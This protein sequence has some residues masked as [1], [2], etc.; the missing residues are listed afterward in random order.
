MKDEKSEKIY[1][2]I[3]LTN[4]ISVP[5]SG[6]IFEFSFTKRQYYLYLLST[7][8]WVRVLKTI[9]IIT[10]IVGLFLFKPLFI[11]CGVVCLALDVYAFLLKKI[12]WYF[13]FA[14]PV[15]YLVVMSWYG[16]IYASFLVGILNLL[17][18]LSF[19]KMPYEVRIDKIKAQ[20]KKVSRVNK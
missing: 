17:F 19:F 6:K 18:R 7:I 16:I 14:Y 4:S 9:L 8:A 13:I 10:G 12:N 1:T 5:H 3:R 2:T 15:G 11:G 20:D